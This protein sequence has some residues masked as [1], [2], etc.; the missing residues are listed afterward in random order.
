M[1]YS[2]HLDFPALGEYGYVI[3]RTNT[4]GGLNVR[5]AVV[6]NTVAVPYYFGNYHP[7]SLLNPA[8]VP[9]A[10]QYTTPTIFNYGLNDD[11]NPTSEVE[12][13]ADFLTTLPVPVPVEKNLAEPAPLRPDRF[14]RVLGMSYAESRH[15]YAALVF[16]PAYVDAHGFVLPA[17]DRAPVVLALNTPHH[18]VKEVR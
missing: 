9:L 18:V 13:N 4:G 3:P 10:A 8:A 12:A 17:A 14:A 5:A 7:G 6:Y 2:L 11:G 15:L 16:D 1:A